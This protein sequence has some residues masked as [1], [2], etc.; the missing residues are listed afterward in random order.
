VGDIAAQAAHVT[1]LLTD[2]GLHYRMAKTG[3]W[4]A[5]ERFCTD[6]IIPRY[7][8]YYAEILNA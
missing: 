8:R 7:E 3:R 1:A 4:N 2:E 5:G 6:K